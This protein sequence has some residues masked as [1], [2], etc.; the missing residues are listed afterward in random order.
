MGE[1]NSSSRLGWIS[2]LWLT[3]LIGV[4]GLFAYSLH[5]H[6]SLWHSLGKRLALAILV[7]VP[8]LILSAL[9]MRFLKSTRLPTW[10]KLLASA[11]FSY[12]LIGSFYFFVAAHYYQIFFQVEE[13]GESRADIVTIWQGDGDAAGMIGALATVLAGTITSRLLKPRKRA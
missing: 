13:L 11:T 8:L 4:V 12:F 5:N 2:E 9:A 3:P 6:L 7:V 10:A 1:E